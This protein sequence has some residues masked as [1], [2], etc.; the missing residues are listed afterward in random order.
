[1][2]TEYVLVSS[3]KVLPWALGKSN[4]YFF[5]TFYKLNNK[6][7]K[8]I[9]DDKKSLL[10]WFHISFSQ[11]PVRPRQLRST[12]PVCATTAWPIRTSPLTLAV[13]TDWETR[14]CHSTRRPA[15]WADRAPSGTASRKVRG[16]EG[17]VGGYWQVNIQ[18]LRVSPALQMFDV[19]CNYTVILFQRPASPYD[20]EASPF[21]TPHPRAKRIIIP[22]V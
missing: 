18:W 6:S 17:R 10:D 22:F 4:G 3:S 14:A 8:Y 19:I 12:S 15:P 2:W 5:L 9:N 7:K 13:T 21:L 1:M 20:S 11:P 16:H